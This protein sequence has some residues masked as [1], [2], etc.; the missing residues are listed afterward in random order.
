[1]FFKNFFHSRIHTRRTN[2]CRAA[3]IAGAS[4]LMLTTTMASGVS[5]TSATYLGGSGPDLA[6]AI[7]F[8][9][10]K[11]IYVASSTGSGN[12][13]GLSPAAFSNFLYKGSMQCVVT[14]LD[15]TATHVL[16]STVLP[17]PGTSS[18]IYFDG[19][20]TSDLAWNDRDCNP[21][22]IRVDASGNIFVAGT[23]GLI[24]IQGDGNHDTANLRGTMTGFVTKIDASGKVDYSIVLGGY[25]NSPT[26][27]KNHY[28]GERSKTYISSLALDA[29]GRAYVG[30][31]TDSLALPGTGGKLQQSNYLNVVA[32]FLT[33]ID[34]DGSVL[35]STFLGGM[36]TS[37]SPLKPATHV[38]TIALDATGNLV[39]AGS[40]NSPDMQI[41]SDAFGKT[42][43]HA[44]SGFVTIVATDLKT[45]AYGSYIHAGLDP[46]CLANLPD[47]FTKGYLSVTDSTGVSVDSSGN[48]YVVGTT[49]SPCLAVTDNALEKIPR[50]STAGYLLRVNAKRSLDYA[51][52]LD[53]G[54]DLTSS[55]KVWSDSSTSAG[56]DASIYIVHNAV[57]ATPSVWPTFSAPANQIRSLK[58]ANVFIEHI[59]IASDGSSSAVTAVSG[60]GGTYSTALLGFSDAPG[61]KSIGLVGTTKNGDLPVSAAAVSVTNAG[62]ADGFVT[63]LTVP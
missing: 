53:L 39:A 11:N 8:D 27:N 7:A 10:S 12:F 19:A 30:G 2:K 62:D 49:T 59:T 63:L 5:L 9:A 37:A 33:A 61:G 31:W 21:T 54:D 40:T 1:M 14:K 16:S 26:D 60:F 45:L 34:T 52:Y 44:T 47:P 56:S 35:A 29:S 41:S 51:T 4:L 20:R 25:S 55:M 28:T 3:S 17:P 6:K 36:P 38:N 32:G 46:G 22:A 24:H 57:E 23:T 43:E 42:N 48:I 13:P 15:A 18:A 58:T 50:A